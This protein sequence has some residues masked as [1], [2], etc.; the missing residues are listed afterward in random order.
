MPTIEEADVGAVFLDL[1]R[2]SMRRTRTSQRKLA[3]KLGLTT[4]GL[5]RYMQG[6]RAIPFHLFIN[7]MEAMNGRVECTVLLPEGDDEPGVK[8][9]VIDGGK[10]G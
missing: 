1:I 3:H 7:M 5:T 9:R 4:A 6:V 10:R 8:L 2:Q